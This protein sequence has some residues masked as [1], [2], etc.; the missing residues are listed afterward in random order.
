MWWD[1]VVISVKVI[2]SI[3][4]ISYL[5]RPFLPHWYNNVAEVIGYRLLGAILVVPAFTKRAWIVSSSIMYYLGM[6][7]ILGLL[8]AGAFLF[9][10]TLLLELG[11]SFP[12]LWPC[13]FILGKVAQNKTAWAGATTVIATTVA[14]GHMWN[15]RINSTKFYEE[16]KKFAREEREAK[17]SRRQEQKNRSLF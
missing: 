15:L 13:Y 16:M 6:F 7:S 2:V 11:V 17:E 9:G 4:L 5:L 3:W 14:I 8:I 1:V 12:E 10:Y